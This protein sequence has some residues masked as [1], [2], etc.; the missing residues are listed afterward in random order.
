MLR[1]M[2]QTQLRLYIGQYAQRY[3]LGRRRKRN[4]TETVRA[5]AEYLPEGWPLPHPSPLNNRWLSRNR[6]FESEVIPRLQEKV[7]QIIL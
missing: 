6:W 7:Q 2:P 1:M 5:Y 4:L 3:Y